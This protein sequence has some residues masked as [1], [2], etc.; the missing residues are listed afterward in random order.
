ML[1]RIVMDFLD[2]SLGSWIAGAA[3]VI[4]LSYLLT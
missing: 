1:S 3:L 4:A 2:Q